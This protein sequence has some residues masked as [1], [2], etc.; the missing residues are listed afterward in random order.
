MGEP[1][2]RAGYDPLGL[3]YF[4]KDLKGRSPYPIAVETVT[5]NATGKA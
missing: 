4:E 2:K 1:M 5:L 3:G